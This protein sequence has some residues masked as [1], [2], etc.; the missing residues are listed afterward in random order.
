[1][2]LPVLQAPVAQADHKVAAVQALAAVQRPPAVLGEAVARLAKVA[3]P[4]R[5]V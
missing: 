1:V 2:E 3:R 5:A 4:G